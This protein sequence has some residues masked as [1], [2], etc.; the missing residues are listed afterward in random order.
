MVPSDKEIGSDD[1]EVNLFPKFDMNE[2]GAICLIEF[3]LTMED[4]GTDMNSEE[5]EELFQTLDSNGDGE[6]NAEDLGTDMNS[7]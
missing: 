3:K 1:I 6:L 7:E 4:L 2:N 5:I